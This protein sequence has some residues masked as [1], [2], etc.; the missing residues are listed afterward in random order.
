MTT[1]TNTPEEITETSLDDISGG[2]HFRN[3]HGASF[4]FQSGVDATETESGHYTQ[5]VWAN[6]R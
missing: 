2:P 3:F 6:T 4:D 1:K 5:M